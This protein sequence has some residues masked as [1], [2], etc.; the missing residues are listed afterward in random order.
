[1]LLT[2]D[3]VLVVL[4]IWGFAAGIRAGLFSTLGTFAG[5][6]AGAMAMPYMLPFVARSIPDGSWRGSVVLGVALGLLALTSSIGSGIGRILRRG[7]DRVHLGG[8]E[9]LLGGGLAALCTA[10]ALSLTAAGVISSG[11]PFLSQSFASS[12]VVQAINRY[13]PQPMTDAIDRIRAQA[14][15]STGMP[16]LKG[17]FEGGDNGANSPVPAIDTD[18]AKIQAAA[19]SVARISGIAPACSTM[20]SGSGFLV[21][22]DLLVTNAHVVAGVANPLVE[23]P[24]EPARTGSVIY[25][26]PVNDLAIVSADVNAKPLSLDDSPIAAGAAGVVQGYPYG[27]PFQ[28]VPARVLSTGRDAVPD[29]YGDSTASRAI[30]V[31]EARVEPGDSGGPLLDQDGT[32]AGI[33][34]A[35]A[36]RSGIGYAMANEEIQPI[37][38]HVSTRN[39]PVSTGRCLAR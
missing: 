4:L 13:T 28:S 22:D 1:M 9:R 36:E 5:L 12:Q 30:H 23:L 39:P 31:L 6:I 11:I 20:S 27:G 17:L 15:D 26:D 18:N 32:V 37:L 29:I 14:F 38:S 21:R 34:F 33:V 25:F 8:V 2:I 10:I 3:I 7:A 19:K 24:N 16:T 35:K